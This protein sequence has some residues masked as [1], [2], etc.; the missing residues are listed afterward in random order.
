MSRYHEARRVFGILSQT[1][2]DV[3]LVADVPNLLSLSLT[4]ANLDGMPLV[5]LR[6]GTDPESWAEL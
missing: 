2:V 4:T 1:F 5:G 6:D 3:R